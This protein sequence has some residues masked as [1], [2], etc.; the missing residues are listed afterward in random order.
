MPGGADGRVEVGRAL[1]SEPLSGRV[2]VRCPYL[3]ET[4][5]S[6]DTLVQRWA[7]VLVRGL[8]KFVPALA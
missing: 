5:A 1:W 8:V 7:K 6:D 3:K 4:C 2:E